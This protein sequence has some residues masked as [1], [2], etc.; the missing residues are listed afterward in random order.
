MIDSQS[1][2]VHVEEFI[3]LEAEIGSECEA[4]VYPWRGRSC[5][6]NELEVLGADAAHVG[7]GTL[8][9]IWRSDTLAD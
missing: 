2:V 3:I 8:A 4:V 1:P 5:P 6:I 7:V 9:V